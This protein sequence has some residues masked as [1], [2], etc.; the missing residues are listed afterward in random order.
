MKLKFLMLAAGVTVLVSCGPSY[1][2]TDQPKTTTDNATTVPSNVQ[3]AFSTQYPT[4]GGVVWAPYDSNNLPI[5]WDLS[6]WPELV[7]GDYVATF[8]LNDDQYY[9]WYDANGNWIGST[10]ALRDIKTLPEPITA[11]I[12]DKF[13]GYTIESVSTEMQKDKTAYE[14]R[15]KNGDNKAKVVVDA[16]GN[17]IKQKTV[18]K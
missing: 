12:N 5:D 3:T 17:I 15:L 4:A 18:T 9:A 11:T 7:S 13:A 8:T 10:Y 2:V 16:N 14:I 6:G 1:R